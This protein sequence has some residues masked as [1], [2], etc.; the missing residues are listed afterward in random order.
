MS[1]EPSAETREEVQTRVSQLEA[2]LKQEERAAAQATTSWERALAERNGLISRLR[3]HFPHIETIV[4]GGEPRDP[5]P[6][7]CL[8]CTLEDRVIGHPWHDLLGPARVALSTPA[9]AAGKATCGHDSYWRT[10]YGDCMACQRVTAEARVAELERKLAEE[11]ERREAAELD[12]EREHTRC[13]KAEAEA[14]WQKERGENNTLAHAAEIER[15]RAERDELATAVRELLEHVETENAD[16]IGAVEAAR[17]AL[18]GR[19]YGD[20]CRDCGQVGHRDCADPA[21][22][23]D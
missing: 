22:V 11:T 13:E 3:L 1:R 8:R 12:F 23:R 4:F 18:T 6:P 5:G 9:P 21:R 10:H 14:Q 20:G 2:A 7:T 17:L 15:L 19:A 16:V